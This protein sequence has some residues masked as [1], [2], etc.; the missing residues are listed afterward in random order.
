[1]IFE[2][3]RLIIRPWTVDDAESLYE[4]AKDP[5]VGP[6]A[7][8]PIHT[9]ID[10]SKEIIQTVLSA[11]ETYAVCLKGDNIAIGSIGLIPP[12]Q[13]HTKAADDEI[14]IGYWIGVPFWGKGLIPEAVRKLQE[15]AFN[16]LGIS[17]MWCGYYDGNEKSKRCQEKC[18]FIF[19]HTEKN[20]PCTLMGDVRTEHFTRITKKQWQENNSQKDI[21]VFIHGKGG[22]ASEAKHYKQFFEEDIYGFDYKSENPWDAKI[23]F[24]D[25]FKEL[26]EKYNRITLIAGSIGAYFSMSSGIGEFVHKA[27]FVSPIVNLEKLILDMIEWAGTTEQELEKKK[28]I[29]VDFGEDLSWDYLQYVRNNGICWKVPT[30][31]LYGSADNLQSLDT[32]KEFCSK[33]PATLTVMDGGEHW[34]HTKEQMEFL[35]EWIKKGNRL[36]YIG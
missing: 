28:I 36:V 1:M 23:E 20:K 18:G 34:F 30:D 19:H 2:T 24:M 17:T 8:W 35:D 5:L 4:Y 7:G 6:I 33:S 14:E 27:Y 13:S 15:H 9:S 21:V 3:E 32:M 31:I 10:N 12:A 16:D 25:K 29:P 11:D 26:S 22:S